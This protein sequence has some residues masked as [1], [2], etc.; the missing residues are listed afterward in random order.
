[1]SGSYNSPGRLYPT[2]FVRNMAGSDH[3]DVEEPW[4]ARARQYIRVVGCNSDDTV[5]DVRLSPSGTPVWLTATRNDAVS[6]APSVKPVLSDTWNSYERVPLWLDVA[7]CTVS[8][9]V[10][11]ESCSPLMGETGAG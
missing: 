7:F 10:S 6:D 5:N 3:A 9:G 11:V 2:S 1:M 8:V 4:T